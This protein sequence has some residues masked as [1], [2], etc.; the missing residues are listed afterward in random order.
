LKIDVEAARLEIA[1]NWGWILVSGFLHSI[2]GGMAVALPVLASASAL[3][4]ISFS[5]FILG[6]FGITGIFFAEKGFKAK[7]FLIGVANLALA[8][9]MSTDPLDALD[10]L[11]LCIIALTIS[12]GAHE[13][14]FAIRNKYLAHR[15]WNFLS[16]LASIAVGVYAFLRRP[17]SSLVVPGFALGVNLL[18]LGISK[19]GI[20]LYGQSESIRLMG[21]DPK[22]I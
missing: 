6:V 11:T 17:F 22:A 20:G 5:L 12:E 4:I 9:F 15:K 8:G 3:N 18:S 21:L 1:K 2:A 7:S 19:I 16:G 14:A 10:L 13:T